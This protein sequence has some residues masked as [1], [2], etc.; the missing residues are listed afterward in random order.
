M[1]VWWGSG[2]SYSA[3]GIRHCS[4]VVLVVQWVMKHGNNGGAVS[5]VAMLLTVVQ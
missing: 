2:L 1:E 5:I 4:M 3:V